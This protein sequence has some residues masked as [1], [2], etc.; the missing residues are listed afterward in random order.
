MPEPK[1]PGGKSAHVD[2][3]AADHLPPHAEW[4]PM[5]YGQPPEL[6]KYPDRMNCAD[7][8]LDRQIEKFGERPV[9]RRLGAAFCVG[10]GIVLLSGS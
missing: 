5:D 4:P 2:T 6:A 10:L 1:A 9:L 7:W 3:F 8:L